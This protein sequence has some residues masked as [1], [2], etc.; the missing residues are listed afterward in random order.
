MSYIKHPFIVR[1]E[2]G[3]WR[4]THLDNPR[5]SRSVKIWSRNSN[6]L[7]ETSFERLLAV[8]ARKRPAKPQLALGLLPEIIGKVEAEY[9]GESR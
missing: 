8:L 6:L 7:I 3:R 1:G 5:F 4:A 9:S 2:D